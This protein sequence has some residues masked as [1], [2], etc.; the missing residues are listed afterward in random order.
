MATGLRSLFGVALA[1]AV[2]APVLRD[3][4]ADSYPLSTYPMF[5]RVLNQPRLTFAEGVSAAGL[6]TRLPPRIV[7]SDEPMQAMRTLKLTAD[8]GK[9]ALKR[10]CAVMAERVAAEPAFAELRQVRIMRAQFDPI[11]YFEAGPLPENSEK[12]AQ[13]SVKR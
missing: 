11:R 4:E 5:A 7:G 13:C 8:G 3:A 2:A 12:L 10:F 6:A 1:L 9:R